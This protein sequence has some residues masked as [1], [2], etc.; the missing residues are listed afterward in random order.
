MPPV[1]TFT[2]VVRLLWGAI[3]SY[4]GKG[5]IRPVDG[6]LGIRYK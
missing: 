3:R 1:A 2:A 6:M 4:L 5:I